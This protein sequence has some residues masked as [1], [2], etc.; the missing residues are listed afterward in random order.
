MAA[1]TI[2][3]NMEQANIVKL[4]VQNEIAVTENMIR[5]VNRKGNE[6]EQ[7]RKD[8]VLLNSIKSELA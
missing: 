8:L 1:V 4:L 6:R 3:L 2:K 5:D 7:S